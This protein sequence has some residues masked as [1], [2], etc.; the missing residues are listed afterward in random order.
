MSI[1]WKTVKFEDLPII[2]DDEDIIIKDG[3]AYKRSIKKETTMSYLLDIWNIDDPNEDCAIAQVM[4]YL[5]NLMSIY[6]KS[7]NEKE[8]KLCPFCGSKAIIK[9]INFIHCEDTV[10]CGA[11]IE[12]G[13]HGDNTLQ[14]TIESWN[15]RIVKE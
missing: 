9:G 12:L 6:S 11:Q 1:D 7:E 5:K 10:N 4:R 8:L 2:K 3:E 15:R 13:D 14:F